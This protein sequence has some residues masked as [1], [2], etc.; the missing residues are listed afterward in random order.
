M[1]VYVLKKISFKQFIRYTGMKK[2]L[3]IFVICLLVTA[4]IRVFGQDAEGAQLWTK[5]GVQ[6][7]DAG[8]YEE[9]I[10]KFR[11]A[12]KLDTGNLHAGYQLAS[13][14]FKLNRGEEGISYL[15]R[16]NGVDTSLRVPANELLGLIYFQA[17]Q[18][19]K[20]EKSAMDVLRDDPTQAASQ[21][22]Y[23]LVTLH[24]NKRAAS[25]LGFC[26]F[27][28]LE[29]KTQRSAEAYRNIQ[30]I[31]Q[32]GALRPEPGVTIKPLDA[33]DEALNLAIT[34][35]V[36][37]AEREKHSTPID[38]LAVQLKNIFT[39][40]GQLAAKQTGNDFFRKYFAAYF[41]KLA[42]SPNMEAFARFIS[43]NTLES[44]TWIAAH[45]NEMDYLDAWVATTERGF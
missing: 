14:L 8:K 16:I 22:M 37:D 17:K 30:H 40:V 29:P 3:K 24:Q 45:A 32:G 10:E 33:N 38:L 6:L 13:S 1:G 7:S 28:L 21:R 15:Q 42:Q 31:L 4:S 9:A 2:L 18:Y 25:I 5:E 35:A 12:L 36:A 11:Q 43:R 41:Y 34:N 27:I 39:S 44:S 20:A 19:D 23:A 26:S